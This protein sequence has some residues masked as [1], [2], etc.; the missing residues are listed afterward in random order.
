MPVVLAIWIISEQREHGE[1]IVSFL[2][3][4]STLSTKPLLIR[5]VDALTLNTH[6][7]ILLFSFLA[8]SRLGVWIFDLTTQQLTQTLVPRT[9]RSSFAGVENSVVNVFEVLGAASA[10]AFPRVEQ[11]PWLALA[12]LVSVVVSWC[13]YAYWVRAQRGHLIHWEKFGHGQ[14]HGNNGRE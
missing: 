5:A 3:F 12:S 14:G 11:Y 2:G 1:R 10:I 13:M 9:Q 8:F 6:W 7:S 4:G